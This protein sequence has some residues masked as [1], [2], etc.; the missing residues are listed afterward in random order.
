MNFLV[1]GVCLFIGFVFVFLLLM[2]RRSAAGALL[3]EATRAVHMDGAP[4]A[5]R[6]ALDAERLATPFTWIR[7]LIT[8]EP[9]PTLVRRLMLAGYRKP[10]HA[11]IFLGSRLA[12][13]AIAGLLV[14]MFVNNNSIMW[15]IIGVGVGFFIPDF[16]LNWA[17]NKR[18]EEIRLSLPDGLDF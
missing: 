8:P 1:L 2:P 3:H 12:I 11:D 7:K 17:V 5:W 14:A 6:T 18:R 10:A 15:F 16:W 9:N 4:P 13:P